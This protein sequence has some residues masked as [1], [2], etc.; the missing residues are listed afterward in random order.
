[1]RLIHA[2]SMIV[3]MSASGHAAADNMK[4][5]GVSDP[6]VIQVDA[7]NV[8]QRIMRIKETIVVH[9]G[10]L[11]LRFPKWL[12][13]YH[14]PAGPIDKIAGLRIYC[15]GSRLAWRR[16]PADVYSFH[17]D[18]PAGESQV[19]AEFEYLTPADETQGRVVMTPVMLNLQWNS[20]L[21]YPAGREIAQIR[22]QPQVSY[23]PGWH[24]STAL[25][26]QSVSGDTVVY[27]EVSLDTLADSPVYAGKFHETL[28]LAPGA[29]IPVRLQ[30]FADDPRYLRVQ[31]RHLEQHRELVRQAMKLYGSQHY[32]HYDFLV[33]LSD[34][35]SANGL[36]H[37][38]SS[39][40]GPA[41]GYF[42]DWTPS[43]GSDHILSHEF[44][45]SWN[46]KYR[47][48]KGQDVPDFNTPMDDRLLWLYEGQ[49]QYWGNAL[50]AR[51]GLRPKQMSLD[52]LAMVVATYRENRPGLEWRSVLDTTMDPII[53]ERKPQ[54]Y[55]SY[56]LSEDYYSAGQLIWLGVDALIRQQTDNTKSLD[57]FAKTFFGTDGNRWE[58]PNY[59]TFEDVVA[60]LNRVCPGHW[61]S[62]LMD[63]LEGR[64]PFASSIEEVGWRLVFK[65]TP[66]PAWEA[67]AHGSAN[68]TYSIGATVGKEGK[69][70]EVRWGGPS[71]DAG[72]APG[73]T[74]V[75]VSGI[76][77][78]PESL[79]EAIGAAKDSKEPIQLM[80]KEFNRFRLINVH[81]SG[82]P[83]Y[84]SLERIPGRP[85]YL[86]DIFSPLE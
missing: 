67:A 24:A 5:N 73:M 47:R 78:S 27:D 3:A 68:E 60:A 39:E 28:D 56:Q 58:E 19:V 44:S 83:R 57:D 86:A 45:H 52:T 14:A 61:E 80:V 64:V 84:P 38:R 33:S 50:A 25:D 59:Y 36:E 20:L 15:G 42:S 34:Q 8:S 29:R 11:T 40:D 82:G 49:T 62:Y 6:I 69:V 22:F 12:P 32:D 43:V 85:D 18:V 71:F 4:A 1:M 51:A 7:R 48:P 74:I 79:V 41:I 13:G 17:I 21:L 46:G 26:V 72:L 75:A 53:A 37:Q 65:D 35:L 55:R 70:R 31:P 10:A 63:R 77:Y 9:D 76:A 2:V 30:L 16:D 66:T 54:P 81:Y 23:P